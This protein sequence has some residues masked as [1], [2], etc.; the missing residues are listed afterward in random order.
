[1]IRRIV[2]IVVGVLALAFW[3]FGVLDM[4][5]MLSGDEAYLEGYPAESI[6]FIQGFPLWR[7]L[8][9]GAS[10]AAGV[11][12]AALLLLRSR[13]AGHPLLAAFVL[14]CAP[15]VG[16]DLPFANG[17]ALYGTPGLIGSAVLCALA[18]AFAVAAYLLAKR[19]GSQ[20]AAPA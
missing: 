19:R 11:A 1:M 4:F 20:P 17:A 15:L 16:Y 2:A 6:A 10:L 8:V 18:L 9:W 13:L 5:W 3:G 12:G 14:M 7:K